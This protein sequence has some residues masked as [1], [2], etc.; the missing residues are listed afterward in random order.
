MAMIKCPECG[1][2][3]SNRAPV[4]PNCGVEIEGKVVK[5]P[6]CG[7]YYF[8]AKMSCPHCHKHIVDNGIIPSTSPN[9]NTLPQAEPETPVQIKSGHDESAT[10][11]GNTSNKGK[12][13]KTII[14]ISAIIAVLIV[15][16]VLIAYNNAQ[17]NKEMEE[18]NTA[19]SS[20]D[21]TVLQM[22]L[23]NFKDAPQEHIDSITAH[24]QRIK[25]QDQ[26]WVDAVV[27][28]SKTA[29]LQY[30]ENHPDSPYRQEALAKIDSIDWEQCKKTN[31]P[32]AY[33]AY[34]DEH[35]AD[36]SHYEEAVIAMKKIESAEVSTEERQAI[37]SIFHNFFLSINSKDENSLTA[38]VSDFITFLGKQN[39]TKSDIVAFMHKLYKPD[40]E[41]MVWGITGS[42]DI[43]KKEIG[44]EQY[45]YDTT[46]TV[47]QKVKKTDGT[48]TVNT[49]RIN[50]KVNP[51][52]K[53]TD[54]SMTK[55]IE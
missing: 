15:G 12:N 7:E 2:P 44:D 41:E 47:K 19:M 30:I 3:I 53:M 50:A 34:I 18:Y 54:M 51:D 14:I 46:F 10:T 5:C 8:K 25:M 26:E 33:Q 49:Y 22:Y 55:I 38:D 35:S 32:E 1:H 4:C 48:E 20:N 23:D 40:I 28:G 9:S 16:G 17:E 52:W 43:T 24:L 45:E 36:G 42:Y 29:L 37:N 21:P 13:N 11:P 31:T 27:S 6:Y 39:A